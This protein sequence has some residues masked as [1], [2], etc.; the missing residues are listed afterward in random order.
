MFQIAFALTMLTSAPTVR[1]V[2]DAAVNAAIKEGVAALLNHLRDEDEI[3][4]QRGPNTVTVR[5]RVTK[6]NRDSVQITTTDR[7]MLS[8]TRSTIT[9]WKQAGLVRDE[10]GTPCEQGR[11]TLA[12]LGLAAAGVETTH[13][14]MEQLLAILEDG[15]GNGGGTYVHGLRASL[16]STL[17]DRPLAQTQRNRFRKLLKQDVDWLQRAGQQSGWYS[18]THA[19]GGGDHSNTQFANLG[20]WS[21]SISAAEVGIG[22]WQRMGRHWLESQNPDGGWAYQNGM[23]RSTPS[24]TVAGCNSLY[25]ALDRYYTRPEQSYKVFEGITIDKPA[26]ERIKNIHAAISRGDKYLE[27]HPPDAAVNSSYELFGLERLGL[28]SGRAY[29]G[30]QD[31]FRAYAPGVCRRSWGEDVVG[32]AFA[33]IFLVHGQAP[34]LIQKLEHGTSFDDW[35]Y[36]QRDL[37]NLTR[38]FNRTF[39]RLHRWQRIPVSATLR[40]MQDA[41]MLYIAGSRALELPNETLQRIREYVNEGGTVLLH[42]DRANR[43]FR[44]AAEPLFENLFKEYGWRFEDVPTDHAI[45]RC[46]FGGV[47]TPW[48]RAAP[49]RAIQDGAR[50]PV[51]LCPV[52]IAGAWQQD[53]GPF[54]DMFRIF[55]NLRVY[56]APAY[57]ELPRRLRA[58][59]TSIG[60]QPQRGLIRV[61]RLDVPGASRAHPAA[62]GRF[63]AA[64]RQR[65]GIELRFINTVEWKQADVVHLAVV[66]GNKIDDTFYAQLRDYIRGGGMLLLDAVDGQPASVEAVRIVAD[67]LAIG[68]ATLLASNHPI[69]SGTMPLARALDSLDTT[70]AGVGLRQAGAMPPILIQTGSGGGCV[71]QCP[72]D[73]TAGMDGCYIWKRIGYR[74]DSTRRLV[75][76]ILLWRMN[77]LSTR[78]RK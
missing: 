43:K 23:D 22:H 59:S 26:R 9:T 30:G 25:I 16:W 78:G 1:A 8:I 54:E 5:G 52:D 58:I 71:L 40:D 57:H 69:M 67:K 12:A 60:Q 72:F 62:W 20:L 76:N 77:E 47:T 46:Q 10:M 66:A 15:P 32:D 35:N 36:Y 29:L 3:T 56:C 7:K 50:L 14:K 73:L 75:E 48:K 53:R 38:F 17:L 4:Y 70:E 65:A 74:T 33:I 51:I 24:M 34:I 49:L 21:G 68:E 55:A 28:A 2:D 42:A 64:F 44:D 39:E 61:A 6:S 37:S 45:Y 11:S 13:P 63:A 19:G 31:W 41:P 27:A 18:Y